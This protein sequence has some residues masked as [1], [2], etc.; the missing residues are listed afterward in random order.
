MDGV[1]SIRRDSFGNVWVG[2]RSKGLLRLRRPRVQIVPGSERARVA[3]I[4][5]DNR[6]RFWFG[7]AE[8]LW[9]E[10]EGKF[11]QMPHPEDMPTMRMAVLYP[12][13]AGGVWICMAGRG[14]WEFDPD[15]H[16]IPIQRLKGNKDDLMGV[17]LAEDGAD[18][19]WFGDESGMVGRLS[20]QGTNI[21]GRLERGKD[22]RV[23]SFL[24]DSA[25][26]VWARI[27]GTA[28]VRLNAQGKEIERVGLAEG[29]PVNSVRC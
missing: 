2:T 26:G 11:V 17:L 25:G 10:R 16:E 20:G 28:M 18:G 23:V 13:P 22:H 12:C 21:V 14:L 15:R 6:G 4:T 8:E 1:L 5:F 24:A 19:F 29:L 27:E 7:S 9:F 3:R